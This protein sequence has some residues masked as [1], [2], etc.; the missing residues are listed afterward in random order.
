MAPRQVEARHPDPAPANA[1]RLAPRNGSLE[2]SRTGSATGPPSPSCQGPAVRIL[3]SSNRQRQRTPKSAPGARPVCSAMAQPATAEPAARGERPRSPSGCPTPEAALQEVRL[4][5]GGAAAPGRA[6]LHPGRRSSTWELDFPRPAV[7]RMEYQLALRCPGAGPVLLPDSGNPRT[8]QGPFG[9]KSVIEFPG[10]QP[11]A[12]LDAAHRRPAATG[13]AV[14]SRVLGARVPIELWLTPAA[15]AA[16]PRC[17]CWSTT[18]QYARYAALLDFL[19]VACADVRLPPMRAA[20]LAPVDRNEH[21]SASPAWSR[22]WSA[23]SC[24]RCRR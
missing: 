18:V 4:Y 6:G 16:A 17:R 22:A 12:W 11:P 15:T 9:E 21:Y 8:A 14:P 19:T 10:Y 2:M 3:L 13:M 23:R 20:L 7:D 1:S 24:R 5:Q